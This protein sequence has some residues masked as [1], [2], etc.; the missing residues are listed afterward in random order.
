MRE[1]A[2]P[3]APRERVP[4]HRPPGAS[5]HV[6]PPPLTRVLGACLIVVL[7]VALFQIL[8]IRPGHRWGDDFAMYIHHAEN[9]VHGESY[10][11]TGYI[12][13][14]RAQVGPPT[15]P[16]V[17]PLF[18][19][20]VY[21]VFGLDFTPMKVEVVVF[22]AGA[23]A[24]LAMLL[25][26]E[27]PAPFLVAWLAIVGF[28]PFYW[29]FKDD[30]L[31]DV[32]FLFFTALA[33]LLIHR[34]PDWGHRTRWR[35]LYPLAV[36]V[37]LYLAVGTRAVGLALAPTL[38]AVDLIR[39]RRLTRMTFVPL[40]VLV[41]LLGAQ[42]L[43]VH[44]GGSYLDQLAPTPAAVARNL[45]GYAGA[46]QRIWRS[47]GTGSEVPV[48]FWVLAALALVGFAVRLRR[49]I[50]VLEIWPVMYPIPL[51]VW[52]SRPVGRYLIPW[53]PFF[54][55]FVLVG[56]LAAGRALRRSLGKAGSVVAP[57]I[58]IAAILVSYV[59]VYTRTDFG[60][61]TGGPTSPVA[62]ELWTFVKTRTS[63]HD[64][65]VFVKPRALS[66]FTG[67]PASSYF[68]PTD[69]RELWTYM[70]Q[71]RA[72]YLISSPLDHR[73]LRRFVHDYRDQLAEVFSAGRFV[74]YRI[75]P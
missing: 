58:V 39:N 63:P 10:S 62:E 57:A 51:L 2:A 4:V 70:H 18:L 68:E 9:I 42:G 34:A 32:P 6:R 16:P 3:A 41:V 1:P 47:D 46:L 60:P 53:I 72:R 40:G 71:I 28:S 65:F 75:G 55:F 56:A 19:A 15:Y 17:F 12:Y 74:V 27:I 36:G 73:Y 44:G 38:L 31:S 54:A 21:K 49:R 8:T 33:L 52:H 35:P 67:R 29:Q 26:T 14:A 64:V 59:R 37:A 69:Q 61:I 5:D 22:F 48:L 24:L 20:P 7:A 11:D 45:K 43:F 23:L 30:V 25:R 13:T 66:L 50:T